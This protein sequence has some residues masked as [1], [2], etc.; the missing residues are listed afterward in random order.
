MAARSAGIPCEA[1]LNIG[2]YAELVD[3]AIEGKHEMFGMTFIDTNNDNFHWK[4][5]Y[6]EQNQH[7]QRTASAVA[8]KLM[9]QKGGHKWKPW[10]ENRGPWHALAWTA[11][12]FFPNLDP[13]NTGS[14]YQKQYELSY[15]LMELFEKTM[16]RKDENLLLEQQLVCYPGSKLGNAMVEDL[17]KAIAAKNSD[18]LYYYIRNTLHREEMSIAEKFKSRHGLDPI[19]FKDAYMGVRMHVFADF[20]AHQGF[21]GARSPRFNDVTNL[22]V[23]P[24]FKHMF[25][26][27]DDRQIPIKEEIVNAATESHYGHGNAIRYPDQ[28]G[29]VYH[30]IRPFDLKEIKRNNA[31]E[32]T[33]AYKA[34]HELFVEYQKVRG[35]EP[36]KKPS[37]FHPD[38]VNIDF[39]K[40]MPQY[41]KV[42][43]NQYYFNKIRF[44]DF[45]NMPND[46]CSRFIS[47]DLIDDYD[48]IVAMR[49]R[50][51]KNK[52]LN[53]LYFALAALCHLSWVET[54]MNEHFGG[55]FHGWIGKNLLYKAD[56]TTVEEAE[57]LFLSNI[58]SG[59]AMPTFYEWQI[60][61][62][63][64]GSRSGHGLTPI[65]QAV[66][67]YHKVKGTS[68]ESVALV[69]ICN[70]CREWLSKTE[71]RNSTRMHSVLMLF[72]K[73][74][75]WL[76]ELVGEK[77]ANFFTGKK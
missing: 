43:R 66:E 20:W 31:E 57:K 11:F 37:A 58:S 33:K 25:P 6:W 30:Y 51:D 67:H 9:L 63:A 2:E 21:A 56:Q 70:L 38:S 29:Y 59:L 8:S 49:K 44:T 60:A 42:P 22:C 13:P 53:L 26:F 27:N 77:F 45:T 19:L 16:T 17:R 47:T 4:L 72:R 65:D 61:S 64:M 75:Y 35:G 39:F 5:E 24:D 36:Y 41:A 1:A 18:E 71:H 74:A 15:E 3:E 23:G 73:A 12:H 32:F 7:V 69:S 46:F 48:L 68:D 54:K 28:P 55:S 40:G 50:R 62:S 34:M 52:E 10:A 14:T 76:R